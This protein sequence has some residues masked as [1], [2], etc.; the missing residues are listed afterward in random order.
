MEERFLTPFFPHAKIEQPELDQ[1]KNWCK[2]Y[3]LV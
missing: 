2:N 3:L 1:K